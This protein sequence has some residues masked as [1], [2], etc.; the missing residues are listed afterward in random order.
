MLSDN[1]QYNNYCKALERRHEE[2]NKMSNAVMTVSPTSTYVFVTPIALLRDEFHRVQLQ[3]AMD[4]D[5]WIAMLDVMDED[6]AVIVEMDSDGDF[7]QVHL[8]E[9]INTL[10]P[11]N[12]EDLDDNE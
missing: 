6:G 1:A 11:I 2:T 10:D 7:V 12:L 4:E 5:E 8:Q 3:R 9:N